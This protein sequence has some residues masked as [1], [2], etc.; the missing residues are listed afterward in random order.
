MSEDLGVAAMRPGLS[1]VPSCGPAAPPSTFLT[2]D[3]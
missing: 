1:G 3:N 2:Q